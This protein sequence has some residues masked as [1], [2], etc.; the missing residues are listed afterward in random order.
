[1]QYSD[2]QG[3]NFSKEFFHIFFL[4]KA[5]SKKENIRLNF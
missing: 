2:G 1:M 5:L 4:N 3:I